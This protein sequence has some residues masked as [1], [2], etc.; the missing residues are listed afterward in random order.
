MVKPIP[1]GEGL[2]ST[3]AWLNEGYLFLS[4]RMNQ[5]NSDIVE[6]KLLGKKFIT[7]R[8]SEAAELFYD[9][10]RFIRHGVIPQNI[11]DIIIGKNTVFHLDD[12]QH[13]FRKKL[14]MNV[15]NEEQMKKLD[16]IS[17]LQWN[18]A[19]ERWKQTKEITLLDELEKLFTII[20]CNWVGIPLY[21]RNVD[22]RTNDIRAMLSAFS[23]KGTKYFQGN[24]AKKRARRWMS[25]IIRQ[26][27]TGWLHADE[28]TPLYQIAWHENS[29]G[30]LLSIPIVADELLNIIR[31]F[32]A[33]ARYVC[34]G[35][36]AIMQKPGTK[37]RLK[38]DSQYMESFIHEVRRFYPAVPFVAAKARESFIWKEIYF[39]K[40]RLVLLDL[41]GSN[42]HP[43]TWN[44]P[45]KFLPDRFQ[46]LDDKKK[47][48]LIPQGALDMVYGHRCVGEAITIQMM[49][50]SL[51]YL[52]QL[53]YEVPEQD[54][55]YSLSQIPSH[56]NSKIKLQYI[57]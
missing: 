3:F 19:I 16:H 28:D 17:R 1:K 22:V 45:E 6:L 11:A 51:E 21:A 13:H 12:E 24:Q 38:G 52:I 27:R 34:F 18:V 44:E 35:Q 32:V 7:M 10:S 48:Q 29:N 47:S 46:Y 54:L 42:H 53:D 36:L 2:G 26:V 43:H 25:Y 40:N 20:V 50:T 30:K 55:K 57:R 37:Q 41:Y 39:P 8:G 31:P 4:N 5:S 14:Y 33:I 23:N 9:P 49:K 56:P 15:M